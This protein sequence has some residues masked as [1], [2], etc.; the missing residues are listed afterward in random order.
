MAFAPDGSLYLCDATGI[1]RHAQ[2]GTLWERIMEGSTCN[3][4]LPSFQPG[5][6]IVRAG[7]A[8]LRLSLRHEQRVSVIGTIK[9]PQPPR[10]R[11]SISFHCARMKP[12]S[13]R[14]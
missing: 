2:D 12:S 7:E 8:E 11:R 10:T 1:Y 3:L 9:P 5:N 14:L 13:R 4:G 6:M